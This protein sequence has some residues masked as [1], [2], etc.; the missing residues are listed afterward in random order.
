M[1]ILVKPNVLERLTSVAPTYI[2]EILLQSQLAL[3]WEVQCGFIFQVEPETRNQ[4]TIL[5]GQDSMAA[6]LKAVTQILTPDVLRLRHEKL[7][8]DIPIQ[9]FLN[10]VNLERA[11]P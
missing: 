9:D 4:A 6:L 8:R 1:Q 7:T 2:R 10:F 5:L 11:D 3:L